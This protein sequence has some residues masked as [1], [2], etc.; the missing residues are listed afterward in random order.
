MPDVPKYDGTSDTQE[1]ITTYTTMVKGNDLAPHEIESVLKKFGES[2]TRGALEFV[3]WFQKEMMLFSAVP[4][5]WAAEAFIKGLNLRSSDA[6]QKLKESLLK[7]QATT[8][9]DFHSRFESKIR[10]EDE[11]VGFLLSAKG[12]E[13]NKEKSKDDFDM[14]RRSSR[15][16]FFALQTD[17]RPRQRLSISRQ[18]SRVGISYEKHQ[19]STVPGADEIRSE[20]EGSQL[21]CEYHG[22]NGHRTGDCRHLQEEVATLLKNG[23]LREFL[24]DRAKNKYDRNR[25]NVEPSNA[26]ENP[27]RQMI[28]LILG[29]NE[30]N[31]VTFSTTKKTKVSLTHSKS[32][33]EVVEYD[34]NFRE[35]DADGLLLPHNDALVISLNVLDFKIKCVQVDLGSSAIII[36]WRVLEQ[37]KLTGSNSGHKTPRWIQPCER[38]NLRR[39]FVAHEC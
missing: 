11:Q 36:Q 28:N 19:R 27:S 35:E 39:D 4:D 1:H 37:A 33:R 2:L 24:S 34:I 10:I 32:L 31:E 23:H 18:C 17:R 12:R 16:R 25:Y 5:E 21:W 9:A 6:S 20:L 30:I 29:G 15:G 14:D 38:D 3:T 7:F 22:T 13:K 8:W 26:G